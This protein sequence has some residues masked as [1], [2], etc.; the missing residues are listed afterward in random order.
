MTFYGVTEDK[1]FC[2]NI[3]IIDD[4]LVERRVEEKFTIEA[5]ESTTIIDVSADSITI[6]VKDNDGKMLSDHSISLFEHSSIIS[7]DIQ[8]KLQLHM[9]M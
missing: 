3:T 7:I 6:G 1:E 5:V 9:H 4:N 8:I 2:V